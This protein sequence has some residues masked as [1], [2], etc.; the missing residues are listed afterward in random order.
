MRNDD[1]SLR[2]LL[3][4]GRLPGS[5]H[6]RIVARVVPRRWARLRSWR[7]VLASTLVAGMATAGLMLVPVLRHGFTAEPWRAAKGGGAGASLNARCPTHAT[8]TCGP[9]DR[10]VFEAHG[11]HEPALLAAYADGPAGERFWYFPAADGHLASVPAHEGIV[12]AREIGRIGEDWPPG[13]Y[14][15]HL[16]LLSRP[17]DRAAL[18]AGQAAIQAKAVVTV[19]VVP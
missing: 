9:G 8:G 15:V 4:G 19:S 16:F 10:L 17:T 14:A 2:F 3:S 5:A 6:D 18:L 12:L 13:R 1:D 11:S 7:W